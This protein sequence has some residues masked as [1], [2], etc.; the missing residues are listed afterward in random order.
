MENLISIFWF[1]TIFLIATF[2]LYSYMLRDKEIEKRMRYYLDIE[3]KYNRKEKT[4]SSNDFKGFL[5]NSNEYIRELLKKGIT[6]KDQKRIKQQLVAAGVDL[7]PEEYVATRIFFAIILGGL[8]YVFFN[9]IFFLLIGMVFGIFL[10]KMW[11]SAK[12]DRRVD[13]FNDGLQDMITTIVSS[14][15]AGFSFSQALK[16]VSEESESPIKEEM[17]TLLN[18]LN[19]GISL[20]EALNNLNNRM[21]SVDLEIMI[22]AVLIQRQIGG[23][24]SVILEII[25]N[26]IRERKKL[27]RQVKTL[28]AQGR[29][30]AKILAALP[31][32]SAL[33]VY[34]T[35]KEMFIKFITNQYGIMAIVV[36]VFMCT[37]GFVVINKIAKIE[38]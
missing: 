3:G 16:I 19:Y 38:V 1:I 29:L 7:K 32:I 28:T 6:G 36:G 14:L 27:Q 22:Q 8:L 34:L 24:L 11:L 33:I 26:T 4:I 20:E 10:P 30:S 23:N 25:V 5:K 17:A 31:F 12:R 18:E 9:N 21:P 35:N 15:K 37:L 13:K 2:T